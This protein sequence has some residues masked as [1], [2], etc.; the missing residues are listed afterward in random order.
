MNIFYHYKE[1]QITAKSDTFV[2]DDLIG[3]AR[4]GDMNDKEEEEDK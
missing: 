3:K 4:L 1:G 2:R